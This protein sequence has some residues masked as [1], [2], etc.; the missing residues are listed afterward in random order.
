MKSSHTSSQQRL[1]RAFSYYNLHPDI[2]YVQFKR[3]EL[4]DDGQPKTYKPDIA[5][6][7][8]L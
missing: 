6:K 8:R 3:D 7:S 2:D 1:E 5:E 4:T